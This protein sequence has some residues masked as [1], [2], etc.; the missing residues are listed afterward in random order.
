MILIFN[1]LSYNNYTK[2]IINI[3]TKNEGYDNIQIKKG[4]RKNEVRIRFLA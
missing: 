1:L 3:L 4:E 2:N